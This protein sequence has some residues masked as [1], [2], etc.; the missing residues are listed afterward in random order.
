MKTI[1]WGISGTG[2]IARRFADDIRHAGN[3]TL[4]A[5]CA[6]DAQKAREF[7]SRHAGVSAFDSLTSMISAGLIDAVYI[8][9]PNAVHHAQALDCIAAGIPVLVEKPLTADLQQALEIQ[10]A[11][12]RAGV[13]V[14]EAM[15]S[16]YLPTIRA[17]RKAVLGGAIGKVHRLEAD[18][19]WK[20]EFDPESRFF[21]KSRGGGALHDIGIY[22]V[23]LARFFL[24]E[25]DSVT[26]SWRAAPSGADV[27][28]AITM[29][30]GDAEANL[31]C[32][33]DRDG[34]N[35]LI[36]EGD[37]GV[38]VLGPLFI[39]ADG[40][41]VYPSRRLADLAQPG[42]N[43]LA[44]RIRRRLFRSLPLAGTSRHRHRFEGSGLQFEIEAA[45]DAISQGLR[46]EPDNSLAD[47]I[48]ALR[49]ID[50]ILASPPVADR[51]ALKNASE[52]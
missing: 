16:R 52:A 9:T 2:A 12:S 8:A 5:V 37:K 22:P 45:S 29:R 25:P 39:M 38:L 50:A 23:S 17:A 20:V 18:I 21:D 30:F 36:I 14:M 32:G 19:A 43:S 28:A 10:T 34:S 4:T 42:G 24:G 46:Q 1:R 33:F 11:A 40:F 3:A 15:W 41:A 6:R 49:I 31:W 35:R 26:A 44:A 48:A 27:S 47:T 7:A 13:F 51:V